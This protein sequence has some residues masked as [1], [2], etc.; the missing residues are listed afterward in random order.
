[1][2]RNT[3]AEL[4][5]D[6]SDSLVRRTALMICM[7]P[8]STRTSG[9]TICATEPPDPSTKVPVE[10]VMKRRDSPA[11]EVVFGDVLFSPNA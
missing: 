10:L 11:A 5:A 4:A 9:R 6:G 1:M 2:K 7:T 3:H 8:L